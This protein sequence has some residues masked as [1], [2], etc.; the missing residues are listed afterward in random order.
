[1]TTRDP[2]CGKEVDALRARAVG[3]WGGR[4]YYFCSPEHKAEFAGNP[5][6][7]GELGAREPTARAVP[8][9]S[10]RTPTPA[11][12]RAATPATGRAATPSAGRAATPS[13]GRST[14][15][16]REPGS[17]GARELSRTNDP[18]TDPAT[19]PTIGAPRMSVG[20]GGSERLDAAGS[21]DHGEGA[22]DA[23]GSVEHGAPVRGAAWKLILVCALAL[24]AG[25]VVFLL[26]H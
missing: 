24:G 2:V 14:P 3:I 19:D 16:P 25:L 6:A 21:P 12:G 8:L 23:D 13:S 11:L 1:M 10:G 17:G 9:S 4:T 5:A 26:R 20:S 22:V 15:A 18:A 7:Y